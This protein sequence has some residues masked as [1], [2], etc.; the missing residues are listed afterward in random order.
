VDEKVVLSRLKALDRRVEA[1]RSACANTA[2]SQWRERCLVFMAVRTTIQKG[3][4]ADLQ[5]SFK[6]RVPDRQLDRLWRDAETLWGELFPPA[7]RQGR[8]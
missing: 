5:R 1:E 7:K 3:G 6:G 4:I 8:I 2:S